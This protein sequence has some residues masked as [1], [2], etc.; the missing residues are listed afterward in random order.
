VS[1]PR[2]LLVYSSV[3]SSYAVHLAGFAAV[4]IVLGVMGEPIRASGI[5]ALVVLL[6]IYMTF[7]AGFGAF[8]AAL[9]VMLRDVEHGLASFL[10]F[11]FYATPILYPR[12]LVPQPLRDWLWLNP[13]AQLSERLRDALLVGGGLHANDAV[14]AVAGLAVL[15]AGLLFFERL[16]PHFEDFL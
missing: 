2:Q 12:T 10:L 5:P 11:M 16:A 4:L 6:A 1:F 7:A 14:L 13:F 15:F 9:Q 8:L 3:L